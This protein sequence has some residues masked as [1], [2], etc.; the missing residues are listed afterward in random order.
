MVRTRGG[1][2]NVG[3][4]DVSSKTVKTRVKGKKQM[5]PEVKERTFYWLR[6][7]FGAC[8]MPMHIVLNAA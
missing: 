1:M 3:G 6:V 7:S 2:K 5:T 4:E 8:L